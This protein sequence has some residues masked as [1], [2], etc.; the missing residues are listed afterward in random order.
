VRVTF[1]STLTATILPQ[2]PTVCYGATGT[3]I[4]ANGGGGTPPYT[5]LWNTGATTSSI[6]VNVGTYIVTIGDSSGCPPTYDT[7]IVT[8]FSNPITANAGT[9]QN[10]CL[11]NLPINLQGVVTGV[12]TGIWSGG[13]GSYSTSNT[14]LNAVY[15]PS[16]VEIANGSVS[17]VLTTTGNGTCPAGVDT[18]TYS[19]VDFTANVSVTTIPVSCN[20]GS[21]G[22]A[23]I[24]ISGN[25]TPYT[26]YWNTVPAQSGNTVAGLSAGTY[27]VT[28]V[29]SLGCDSIISVTITEP[30][31]LTTSI[32]N[33]QNV[34]CNGGSNGLATVTAYGGSA[35]YTY[36]WSTSAFSQNTSTAGNIPAG[37]HSVTVTDANGC[38]SVSSAVITEPSSSISVTISTTDV[39]CFGL[40]DGQIA[41]TVT[42][43][44][45]PYS[46]AWS[47]NAG[48]QLSNVA[49]NLSAGSY[50]VV[51]SDNFGCR[52][53]SGIIV[54]EPAPLTNNLSLTHVSCFGSNDGEAQLQ[55][56]G[57]TAPYV[58]TWSANSNTGNQNSA[59][60]LSAG[61]YSVTV[62]DQN[63][64]TLDSLF[65]I[66]QPLAINLTT[67]INDINC[68]GGSN[69]S[70]TISPTGGT[71]P[72]SIV[73]MT[74]IGVQMGMNAN[75]LTSGNYTV[76]VTDSLGC[77]E[78][79]N[80]SV[81][82]PDS[83]VL[84][85]DFISPQCN[86]MANGAAEA[87]V[88]G[89]TLP[90]NYDWDA[91]T[92]FQNT[93][94]ATGLN[95]GPYNI[96]VVDANNCLVTSTITVTEP[97]PLVISLT[98]NSTICPFDTVDM[99]VNA[100]GGNGGN[101]F[102]WNHG[103]PNANPV[104][105]SPVYDMTY[106]VYVKDTLGCK[107]NYDTLQMEVIN[108]YQNQMNVTSAGNVCLGESTT[109]TSTYSAATSNLFYQW[110]ANIPGGLGSFTVTPT[111]T[112]TYVL[113]ITDQ[114]NNSIVDSVKVQ[115]NLP[116]VV[117]LPEQIAVGCAPLTVQFFD[118]LNA[119]IP[120]QY[121]W[122]F[123][124]GSSTNLES[125][126]HIYFDEGKYFVT[127]EAM[128]L[129]GCTATTDGSSYVIVKPSPKS[130][131][132]ADKWESDTRE[133]EFVF[134]DLSEGAT[135]IVWF[136]GDG[137]SLV[138]ATNPTYTFPTYGSYSVKLA[139]MN[140]YGCTDTLTQEVKIKPYYNFDVPNAFVPNRFGGNGGYYDLNNPTN[141]V[142]YPISEFVQNYRLIVYNRWGEMVFESTDI[143][144]GWDGYYRGQLSPQDVYVWK[145]DITY[146]DGFQMSEAGDLTLLH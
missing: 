137:D 8:A 106:I 67:S 68:N 102:Y 41:L 132:T 83:L 81:T 87:I 58:Y 32:T 47:L 30:T 98:G 115:V 24:A 126:E 85:M 37:I 91:N 92:G 29:N 89:G 1:N 48:N 40:A 96:T 138:N 76:S 19:L 11:D 52:S 133:M 5:Y 27:A 90:Y 95:A 35:P 46:F 118:S 136:F 100:S 121:T 77:V 55:I 60:S 49:T 119:A 21:N 61:T 13:L 75:N 134:T 131:F 18:V 78:T 104:N 139:S 97:D 26:C 36:Q 57:G 127:L 44:V 140:F 114:C 107:S 25:Q 143:N 123:G 70:A 88:S 116:P 111:T 9:N 146:V 2:N 108:L 124:D 43:G 72:Y 31:V 94:I 101:N 38:T 130:D 39:S 10:V 105:V 12:T 84:Q 17:L 113:T 99:L 145:V 69:G 129:E 14:A 45:P 6:Y 16:P 122:Y 117:E 59:S 34:S 64:C 51:I 65:D 62:T 28:I 33:T 109:I 110:N 128:T 141:E 4:T 71:P 42:G 142:F 125:P 22:S 93:P 63:N 103:L 135:K 144:I 82:Q 80:I 3:T 112:T 66:V 54:S 15:T 73:W 56:F 53:I 120:L 79:A 74:N 23:T 50:G 86:G 7:V 20:G